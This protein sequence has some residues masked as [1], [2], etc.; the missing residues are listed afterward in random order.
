[1]GTEEYFANDTVS[2]SMCQ[3]FLKYRKDYDKK[4]RYFSFHGISACGYGFIE[5]LKIQNSTHI[6]IIGINYRE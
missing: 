6:S 2:D 4:I 3:V 5:S 1:M